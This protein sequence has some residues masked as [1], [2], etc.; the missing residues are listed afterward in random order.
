VGIISDNA[1]GDS[2]SGYEGFGVCGC[3]MVNAGYAFQYYL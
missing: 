3:G 2:N 1:D